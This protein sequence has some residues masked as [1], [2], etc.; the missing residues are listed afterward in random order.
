MF[1][2][3]NKTPNSPRKA[4]Q[5][6]KSVR[7]GHKVSSKI[8][9][10]IGIANDEIEVEKLKKIAYE[11]IAKIK[12]E[13]EAK[14]SRQSLFEPPTTGE[15]AE[16][17]KKRAEENKKGRPQTKKITDIIPPSQVTLDEIVEGKRIVEGVEEIAGHVY[18]SLGFSNILKSKK[19]NEILRSVVLGR[20]V[21]PYSKRKLQK[22]LTQ[23]FDRTHSLDAIYR[24]MDKLFPEIDQVKQKV[25]TATQSLIPETLQVILFDVTTLFFESTEVDELRKFGYSKDCK[26][27]NTQIVLA[28]AT[29][30]DGLPLGYELFTGNKAEVKI[31]IEILEK[32]K[33]LF[34]LEKAIF[35]GDRAMFS[36]ENLALLEK[37]GYN[38]VIAAKL[39]SL[40]KYLKNEIL[41]EKNYQEAVVK[42]EIARVGEFTYRDRKI[43]A[44]YK[45]SRALRDQ[46]QREKLVEKIKK[47][48]GDTGCPTTKL[49][50]NN[51]LKKYTLTK[52]SKTV[53]DETKIQADSSWDGMHGVITN[54]KNESPKQILSRYARLWV[55]EESFRVNKSNLKMRPIYHWKP[56][57]IAAH[58]AI[59]YMTFSVLRHMQ[60]R[61]TLTQKISA[62]D[63]IDTLLDVQ[64][65]IYVHKKTSHRY[66]LPGVVSHNAAK[67][68]KAFGL[69][70]SRDA[71]IYE[72]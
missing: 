55:I 7:N 20:L 16:R 58:I 33:K 51:G 54:L 23:K 24:I 38:Y 19:F 40:P 70:R 39:R 35:V 6:I 9:H 36:D 27:N 44:S 49:I 10:H 62:T 48:I 29:N 25:F 12:L 65:S 53:L 41:D 30:S 4:V 21:Q 14:S 72:P 13:E 11:W 42:E 43:I 26:F 28:L 57:R 59:C 47:L 64:A 18:K 61:I 22:I 56:Q 2:R 3:V 37:N 60:Y 66:R 50:K 46:K 69:I 63:I 31:L 32:W 34:K 71:S 17:L 45:A 8:L 15:F 52:D 67:I 5:I 1:I 68:Y